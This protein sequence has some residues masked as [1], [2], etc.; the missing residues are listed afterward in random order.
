MLVATRLISL[1]T[2]QEKV[3]LEFL[4]KEIALSTNVTKTAVL[5]K[6][7]LSPPDPSLLQLDQQDPA[8]LD[9]FLDYTIYCLQNPISQDLLEKELLQQKYS[10][11]IN[12]TVEL[13]SSDYEDLRRKLSQNTGSKEQIK[14]LRR[15]IL[16]RAHSIHAIGVI[17]LDVLL[18]INSK[19]LTVNHTQPFDRILHMLYVIN[20][21]FFHLHSLP[22][23]HPSND[24]NYVTAVGPYSTILTIP[25]W[26]QLHPAPLINIIEILFPYMVPIFEKAYDLAT[27]DGQ[28]DRLVRLVDLWETKH[29]LQTSKT[30]LILSTMRKSRP[31][32]NLHPF[33]IYTLPPRL[34]LQSPYIPENLLQR[35]RREEIS[36]NA[37]TTT[38]V[39][40]SSLKPPPPPLPVSRPNLFSAPPPPPP[41]PSRPNAPTTHLP[42][43]IPIL[44]FDMHKVAVGST[45]N[46]TKAALTIGSPKYAPIDL[47]QIAAHVSSHVEK[48][49]LEARV[50]EFY[51]KLDEINK[52]FALTAEMRVSTSTAFRKEASSHEP[53][54]KQNANFYSHRP[55]PDGRKRSGSFAENSQQSEWNNKR[56]DR[57]YNNNPNYHNNSNYNSYPQNDDRNR[58]YPRYN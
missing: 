26:Q 45:A 51:R 43:S 34:S 33:E 46:M 17:S 29:F 13:T 2:F 14:H 28:R 16:E 22:P 7:K 24:R 40:S 6:L 42:T 3:L 58:K 41:V 48:G 30:Q 35:F 31:F 50:D 47:A 1:N 38:V 36:P 55:N 32:Q 4:Q 8:L 15:W 57:G 9:Q 39:S 44:K 12:G 27:S 19:D 37:P 21:I 11:F 53:P 49:R 25:S 5:E 20:D 10:S 23:T 18:T 54:T 56:N 52:A